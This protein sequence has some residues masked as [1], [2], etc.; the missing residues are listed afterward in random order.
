MHIG[1][2]KMNITWAMITGIIIKS[3][4]ITKNIRST[5]KNIITITTIE[6]IHNAWWMVRAC[7]M[8]RC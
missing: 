6:L 2:L 7:V 5:I 1:V 4:N 8:G 3:P